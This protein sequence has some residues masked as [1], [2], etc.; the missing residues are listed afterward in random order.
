M[1]GRTKPRDGFEMIGGRVAFVALPRVTRMARREARH[2]YVAD[3]LRDDRRR[4]DGRALRVPVH[5][6]LMGTAEFRTGHAVHQD[7][8]GLHAEAR[9]GAA[10]GEDGGA[11]D[12]PAVDLVDA[13]GAD[14]DRPRTGAYFE[15]E[16]VAGFGGEDLRVVQ[17]ADGL[18]VRI[19]DD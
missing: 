17:P 1:S 12:V 15:G 18:L 8:G 6:G 3:G 9:E 16:A 13:R 11:A 4:G 10:H 14:A 19:K 7:V 5:D 2:Q